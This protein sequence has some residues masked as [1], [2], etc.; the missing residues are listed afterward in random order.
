MTD[1]VEQ[2]VPA[3]PSAGALLR[4]ARE[5]AG[6]HIA[7]LAVAL[8]VP[9][10]KLEAL[11]SDQFDLLPD[12]VF[13]RALASSVCRTLKIDPIPILER[14]PQTAKPRLIHDD[15]GIN[16]PFR[17]PSDGAGPSWMDQLSRPVF[18]IV[19]AL[20]LGALVLVF[21]PSFHR[22][23]DAASTSRVEN[24]VMPPP[25]AVIQEAQTVV[26]SQGSVT[27][28]AES[29]AMVAAATSS[30]PVASTTAVLAPVPLA[31]KAASTAMAS[32]G[33]PTTSSA[34]QVSAAATPRPAASAAS[35]PAPVQ[36]NGLVVFR[37]T[38]D[39][40][41]EVTDAKGTVTL[42]KL[43][44]NGEA[45]GASGNLPLAIVVGRANVTTVQV[46]G[47][48]FDLAPVSRDNVAR[49]EVK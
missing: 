23:D 49:F 40:W 9:V 30:P 46:R 47:K 6:L 28:P 21:M 8:K 32:V 19:F 31:T 2:G 12:A 24:V 26:S 5:A 27:A 36:A 45:V 35:S 41:I 1:E 20:L 39:S 37:A 33:T 13:V 3:G 48:A 25:N 38:G 11:E 29:A 34:A 4:E 22:D 15:N 7:A 16:E 44:T 17:A 10:R 14:L 18:L 42:R 43:L